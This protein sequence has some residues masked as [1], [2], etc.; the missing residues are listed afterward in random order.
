MAGIDKL[1]SEANTNELL[2]GNAVETTKMIAYVASLTPGKG[3]VHFADG[4]TTSTFSYMVMPL[5]G[6]SLVSLLM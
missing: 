2:D 6:L 4:Y 3:T 5:Q 1:K